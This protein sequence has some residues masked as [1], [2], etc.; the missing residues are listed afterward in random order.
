MSVLE[1]IEKSPMFQLS[2][3]SKELF[4]TNF[5]YWL[6]MAEPVIF[7]N[8]MKGMGIE[9]N[10]PVTV[11]REWEHFDLAILKMDNNKIIEIVAIIENKVKSL[12]R[13]DQ[14]DE[15]NK[16]I[17][18]IK[19]DSACKKI[20]LSFSEPGFDTKKHGWEYVDY[21]KIAE[22]IQQEENNS[23]CQYH[24]ALIE[25]YCKMVKGLCSLKNEWIGTAFLSKKYNTIL[26]SDDDQNARNLRINDLR[27]KLIYSKMLELLREKMGNLVSNELIKTGTAFTNSK[28]IVEVHITKNMSDYK[29]FGI[30]AQGLQYR[31]F[32]IKNELNIDDRVCKATILKSFPKKC[33]DVDPF[34]HDGKKEI[35][36]YG[37]DFRYL[38]HRI[39]DES[40]IEDVI[41]QMVSDIEMVLNVN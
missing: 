20:L 25:D 5:L 13:L 15:Y 16:K 29:V 28:G 36:S 22:I 30:Q 31:R 19:K 37:N 4:H 8:V 24:K 6:E 26:I 27:H 12:P 17:E 14:L 3:A 2:L 21:N 35:G 39:S 23:S 34:K 40:T 10:E 11:K 41:N 9:Y 18:K 33:L 1:E 38:Y 7:K 32:V